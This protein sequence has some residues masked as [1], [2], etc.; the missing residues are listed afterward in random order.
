MIKVKGECFLNS[1]LVDRG[2]LMR[3]SKLYY[4]D[5]SYLKNRIYRREHK[6]NKV[7]C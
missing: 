7:A 3:G 4:Y 6:R 1:P 2:E 5:D